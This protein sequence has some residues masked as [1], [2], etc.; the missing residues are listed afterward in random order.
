MLLGHTLTDDEVEAILK[1]HGGF[2]TEMWIDTRKVDECVKSYA[3][4][5]YRLNA[6]PSMFF[7]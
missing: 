7:V 6:S 4:M 2:N 3:E 1:I 5:A